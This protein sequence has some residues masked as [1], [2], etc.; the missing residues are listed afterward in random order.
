MK[1][2]KSISAKVNIIILGGIV[3][4]MSALGISWYVAEKKEET[5]HMLYHA[6]LTVERVAN[7]L[8]YP[9]WYIEWEDMREMILLEMQNPI[10]ASIEIKAEIMGIPVEIGKY[11]DRDGAVVDIRPGTDLDAD[12]GRTLAKFNRPVMKNSTPLGRVEIAI[13]KEPLEEGLQKLMGRII[14]MTLL[15][16]L[17]VYAILSLCLSRIVLKPLSR[18][19][20]ASR[21]LSAK[22][23][24]VAIPVHSR[25]EIGRLSERFNDM[26]DRIRSD[27][28]QIRDKNRSLEKSRENL[29]VTLDAIGDAV[30]VTDVR[31]CIVRMNPVAESLTGW[32]LNEALGRDIQEIFRV[33][34]LET[35]KPVENPVKKVLESGKTVKVVTDNVLVS[36]DG[37]DYRIADSGSPIRLPDGMVIGVVLV[38][39]DVTALLKTREELKDSEERYRITFEKAAMGMA[40]LDAEG[41]VLEANP[42]LCEILGYTQDELTTMN[43]MD[44][45][46]PEERHIGEMSRQRLVSG[47]TDFQ[48]RKKRYIRKDGKIIWVNMIISIV[49]DPAG[50]PKYFISMV[51][52]IT[53]TIKYEEDKARLEAQLRQSQKMEAIG[54]LA[55]GIAH[56][57]NN[58]LW[59]IMGY[60]ELTLLEIPKDAPYR[61][62]LNQVMKAGQRAKALVEQIL[63]FSRQ[64]D[65]DHKPLRIAPL[66]QESLKLLR[67]TLPSTVEIR[68]HLETERGQTLSD[69]TQI[70]QMLM[71]LCS[72][73]ADAMQP[74][75]GGILTVRL[76][77]LDLDEAAAEKHMDLK[78]GPY[79]KLTV[80]DTGIGMDR[81]ILEHIFEPFFT[82]K[83]T[84]KGTGMGLAV[85]HGL[86]K[87]HDGAILV[88]STLG[89]GSVFEIYFPAI[90]TEKEN[91]E[92][93]R[94]SSAPGGTERILFVDDEESLV[95]MNRK[96]L[97]QLGYRVTAST[98]AGK[99]LELFLASPDDFDLLVSDQTM[100]MMTG[101]LLAGEVLKV[102]PDLPVILCTGFSEHL[103]VEKVEAMG[104]KKLIM[105]PVGATELAV[106]IRDVL[107]GSGFSNAAS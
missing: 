22:D 65:T 98:D 100:P 9:L 97:K 67:A 5:D 103:T 89:K 16:S 21:N 61:D 52:D 10:F 74:K 70:H 84:G 72:N 33:E 81:E 83:E 23:Y 75:G 32:P 8:V 62:N 38:F 1:I 95:L 68:R 45:T 59:A 63:R 77:R 73:A 13:R 2:V 90:E 93:V 17:I 85:I 29:A 20:S 14:V 53:G 96:Y 51:E 41:R 19:E 37:V 18:L 27:I 36:K 49:R 101:D 4:I 39:R 31:G 35:R 30:I 24:R 54:T 57:F 58:I 106:I 56:D 55:G 92:A 28:E 91:E 71:N 44:Y 79:I 42:R 88:D 82:T 50:K 15:L 60:T 26:A 40:R 94:E 12:L 107:D 64:A 80:S 87:S 69:P 25:D 47:M 102:R 99:A 6:E 86:V 3:L 43:F 105:K 48:T 78:V 104:V 76:E 34:H 11:R 46:H 66:V 7:N